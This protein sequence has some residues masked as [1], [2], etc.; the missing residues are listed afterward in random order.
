MIDLFLTHAE[1]RVAAARE[2]LRA[3]D[4]AAVERAGH[5]LKS[6]A[7]NLGAMMLSGLAA[8]VEQAAAAGDA[9]SLEALL[10]RLDASCR[11]ALDRLRV[12]RE[13]C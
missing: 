2:G 6:T 13:G 8:E 10:P 4:L 1:P 5:S 9:A 7:A 11:S 3:G 12:E